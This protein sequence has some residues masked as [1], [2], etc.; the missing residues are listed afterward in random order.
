MGFGPRGG[1]D[2]SPLRT[3]SRG[4]AGGGRPAPGLRL[5]LLH[6]AIGWDRGTPPGGGH[7]GSI[8]QPPSFWVLDGIGF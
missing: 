6:L 2:P 4:A 8:L 5:G 3:P 7:L 1:T